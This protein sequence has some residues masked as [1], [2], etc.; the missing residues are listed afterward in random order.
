MNAQ[1]GQF[2]PVRASP[3]IEITAVNW[4]AFP[5]RS[6]R[7]NVLDLR[8]SSQWVRFI[9]NGDRLL[10]IIFE[11]RK[12]V[13]LSRKV[14]STLR[15]IINDECRD[16]K[17]TWTYGTGAAG[18]SLRRSRGSVKTR[19]AAATAAGKGSRGGGGAGFEECARWRRRFCGKTKELNALFKTLN[20]KPRIRELYATESNVYREAGM[21]IAEQ[22]VWSCACGLWE[23]RSGKMES[24][25]VR[26]PVWVRACWLVC[27]LAKGKLWQLFTSVVNFFESHRY[28]S[29]RR[30]IRSAKSSILE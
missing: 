9:I 5:P 19:V 18:E 17:R 22:E 12:A 6:P 10:A 24:R 15:G 11:A 26:A 21:R 29:I 23:K 20:S 27:V 2:W 25:F 13:T 30:S 16:A 8:L 4:N 7:G 14:R 28:T 3:T 1:G